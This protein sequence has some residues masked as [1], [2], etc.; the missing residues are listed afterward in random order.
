MVSALRRAGHDVA[1][2]SQSPPAL[3]ALEAAQRV[4]I[5]ITCMVFLEGTPHGVALGRMA[6]HKRPDIKVLFITRPHLV[7][8]AE[9]VGEVLAMPVTADEV[10]TKVREMLRQT[11][12]ASGPGPSGA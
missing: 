6:R 10:V 8:H 4:D 2:F 12:A 7:S 3:D 5:L 11:D 1:G 9:G